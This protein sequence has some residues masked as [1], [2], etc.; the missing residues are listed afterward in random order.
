[1]SKQVFIKFTKIGGFKNKLFTIRDNFNKLIADDVSRK[2]LIEGIVYTLGD[3]IASIKITAKGSCSF[4]KIQ[5]ICEMG[6][7]EYFLAEQNFIKNNCIWRHLTNPELYNGYYGETHEYILEYP[8]T[9]QYNDEILQNV[10][11]YTRVFRYFT[12][13]HFLGKE[14]SKIELDDVWF[15]KAILYNAQQCSGVLNLVPKTKHNLKEYVSY[16]QYTQTGKIIPFT[17]SDNFYQYNIFW[18]VLKDVSIPM[19]TYSCD[20]LSIDKVI[21]QDNMDYSYRSFKKQPLRAKELK[22]RHL[23]T[24][25]TDTKFITQFTYAPTQISYK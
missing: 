21:N 20:N 14:V 23:L 18:N 8:F 15:D 6:R 7:F 3:N 19:F 2:S 1:M 10:K 5:T 9:Y 25:R 22:I 16:P 11:D 4:E 12:N 13:D 24:N 17:K